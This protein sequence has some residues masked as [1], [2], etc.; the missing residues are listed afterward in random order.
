[1]NK[2][3]P[4]LEPDTDDPGLFLRSTSVVDWE[5]P[6][7]KARSQELCLGADEVQKA[8]RL[9]E[10][11][12]DK[13]PHSKDIGADVVTCRASEV[14]AEGT[15]ICW[16]KSHL[17]AAFLRVQRIPTGFCYQVLRRDPPSEGF[18]L[19]GLN[20]VYLS[21]VGRWVPL[22][23]RGNTGECR[24]EFGTNGEGLAFP[25]DDAGE[26]YMYPT[27]FHDPAPVVVDTLQRF[28]NRTDMW[29]HLPER[30]PD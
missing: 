8:K 17:L 6:K 25:V 5:H 16:A 13:I 24:A 26:E 28:E 1:M 30:L 18:V 23:P 15:G 19:H 14:L 27:V 7:V 29:P 4:Q 11:V 12:R 10:W 20:G 2:N 3:L 22:D 21:N 9:F